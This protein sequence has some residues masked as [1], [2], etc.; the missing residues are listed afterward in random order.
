MRVF[1]LKMEEML[2]IMCGSLVRA[3]SD[4]KNIFLPFFSLICIFEKSFTMAKP[5]L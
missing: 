1:L 2:K 4:K 5:P 3:S